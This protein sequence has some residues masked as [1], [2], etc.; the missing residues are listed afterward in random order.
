M[1]KAKVKILKP[2]DRYKDP[3]NILNARGELDSYEQEPNVYRGHTKEEWWDLMANG[4]ADDGD[5]EDL[6]WPIV[7]ADCNIIRTNLLSVFDDICDTKEHAD[8]FFRCHPSAD[9]IHKNTYLIR[10]TIHGYG[11]P[12]RIQDMRGDAWHLCCEKMD[13][14]VKKWYGVEKWG[15]QKVGNRKFNP[16]NL[17]PAMWDKEKFYKVFVCNETKEK[18]KQE[19]PTPE[20]LTGNNIHQKY[21]IDRPVYV[22][23]K[24][25]TE[26]VFIGYCRK[27]EPDRLECG[28]AQNYDD[29]DMRYYSTPIDFHTQ[30]IVFHENTK[31]LLS[32]I[33]KNVGK[34]DIGVKF[35]LMTQCADNGDGWHE[36]GG[37]DEEV[38]K[39]NNT[40]FFAGTGWRTRDDGLHINTD[41]DSKWKERVK[42]YPDR[43]VI[44][45]C[46]VPK[47]QSLEFKDNTRS[48]RSNC[49]FT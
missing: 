49:Y 13:E 46:E 32:K 43:V 28:H 14:L 36:Y 18:I 39:N 38:S 12:Q 42:I 15:K 44:S 37:S 48:R 3:W 45:K 16:K 23:K 29:E 2:E 31:T 17:K 26:E 11:T 21:M 20:I 5:C 40:I 9:Y 47:N 34:K 22:V 35:H 10:S 19:I 30:R 6:F 25:T 4:F 1:E 7:T 41:G 27:V 33:R 24:G 8:D